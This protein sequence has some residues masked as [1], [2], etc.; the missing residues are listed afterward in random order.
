MTENIKRRRGKAGLIRAAFA[1][2]RSWGGEAPD[3]ANGWGSVDINLYNAIAR[4][5]GKK[6]PPSGDEQR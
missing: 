2:Y 3:A 6:I 1:W 5:K 4:Y